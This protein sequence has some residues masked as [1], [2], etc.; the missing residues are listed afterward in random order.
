[1]GYGPGPVYGGGQALLVQHPYS[2]GVVITPMGKATYHFTTDD[3]V[4]FRYAQGYT[5]G[6]RTFNSQLGQYITLTPEVVKDF[7]AGVRST[8]LDHRLTANLTGYLM[9]WDGR[10]VQTSYFD[11]ATGNFIF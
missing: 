9:Y 5:A 1:A 11:K 7:E 3:N 10:A 8:W 4:Y 6:T 2:P